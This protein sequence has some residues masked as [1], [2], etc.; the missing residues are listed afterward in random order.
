MSGA[1]LAARPLVECVELGCSTETDLRCE[2]P[3]GAGCGE[4][5]CG[6]HLFATEKD[7]NLCAVDYST[8]VDER[9]PE[10]S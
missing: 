3:T 9:L 6:D 8:K 2:G 7:G 1:E 10:T 5:Y 4:P